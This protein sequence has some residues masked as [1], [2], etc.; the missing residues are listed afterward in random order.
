MGFTSEVKGDKKI[1]QTIHT[2]NGDSSKP[3]NLKSKLVE[4][5]K[6]RRK[7]KS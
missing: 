4:R 2:V 1:I 6:D 7:N 5:F 3:F